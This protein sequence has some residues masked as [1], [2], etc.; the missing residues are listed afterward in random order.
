MKTEKTPWLT[1]QEDDCGG[2]YWGDKNKSYWI[3][4][5]RL[6]KY[7]NLGRG[8]SSVRAILHIKKPHRNALKLCSN[9]EYS[10]WGIASVDNGEE[11]LSVKAEDTLEDFAIGH[12]IEVI[13]VE[14]EVR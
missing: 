4:D 14:I 2:K 10:S 5:D 6:R 1:L 13:W 7:I 3:C 11:I 9:E 8:V 12:D